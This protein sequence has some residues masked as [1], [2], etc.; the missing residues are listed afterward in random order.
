MVADLETAAE[1]ERGR[2]P[3][4][5]IGDDNA[6]FREGLAEF[7]CAEGME[8]VEAE[9]GGEVIGLAADAHAELLLLDV[10]MPR[11]SGL[12]AYH[13]LRASGVHTA[14]IFL[15]T[16]PTPAL[17]AQARLLGAI[18][19]LDKFHVELGQL[20]RLV[21]ATLFAQPE[22]MPDIF[23]LLLDPQRFLELTRR[24]LER[25]TR[26]FD[27]LVGLHDADDNEPDDDDAAPGRRGQ[28]DLPPH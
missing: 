4:V 14:A 9:D 15:T 11:L 20:S 23:D 8:V 12:E 24:R 22:R 7:L 19:M 27:Q 18:A 2:R 28:N 10:R 6:G 17:A 1:S 26:T 3:V 25:L 13:H 16:G 5:L 21:H